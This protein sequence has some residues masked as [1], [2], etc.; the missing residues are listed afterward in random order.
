MSCLAFSIRVPQG[1]IRYVRLHC[2]AGKPIFWQVFSRCDYKICFSL[3]IKQLSRPSSD[4]EAIC[5]DIGSTNQKLLITG[6]V[7]L[8]RCTSLWELNSI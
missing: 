4:R 7:I 8:A 1:E 3:S 6:A 2:L 5:P